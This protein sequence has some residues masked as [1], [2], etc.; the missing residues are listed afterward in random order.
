MS[1]EN[2]RNLIG[3]RYNRLVVIDYSH[4]TLSGNRVWLCQC[5]CG[6]QK[7]IQ[8]GHL[9]NGHTKSCGCYS[10]ESI[11][12]LSKTH[13]LSK[14][15]PVYRVWQG[16]KERCRYK[17]HKSY[18]YYGGRGITVCDEW[19]VNFRSFHD[20]CMAQKYQP[21]LEVDRI[22]PHGNYSPE[23]CRLVTH[24]ENIHN[25]NKRGYLL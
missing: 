19:I 16:I 23:N 24:T 10:R 25:Q 17:N 12:V 13:G 8:A 9:S 6:K 3:Q 22:N 20:W 14:T 2:I 18:K 4:Q 7:F 21:G 1:L 11:S 15:S 5:D